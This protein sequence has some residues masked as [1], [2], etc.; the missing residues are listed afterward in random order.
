MARQG[1]CV[2]GEIRYQLTGS[3]LT[4]Y[5]CHCTSCQ[6]RS[7]SAFSLHMIVLRAD[8]T[9]TRGVP[10][11]A[12]EGGKRKRC[13]ACTTGLWSD[14]RSVPD[15]VWLR[16]GT[17]DDTRA[18]QPVAHLWTRSAQRWFAIPTGARTFET[19]PDDPT[20]LVRLWQEANGPA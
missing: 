18:L 10:E 19:Q 13:P 20:E 14:K 7:G 16:P 9:I 15:L 6:A 1:G 3:P 17:L 12:G 11:A 2:C 4:L 8:L 5:A